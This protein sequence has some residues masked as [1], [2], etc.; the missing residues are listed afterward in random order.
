MKEIIYYRTYS[1]GGEEG[2]TI[3]KRNFDTIELAK[4]DALLDTWNDD[5]SLYEV[6]LTFN[7]RVT[8]NERNL[9]D[10]IRSGRDIVVSKNQEKDMIPRNINPKR[11]EFYMNQKFDKSK[12][13]FYRTYSWGGEEGRTLEKR[14]FETIDLAIDDARKDTWNTGFTIAEVRLMF[15]G[16]I[17]ES[18][19]G[20]EGN[21]KSGRDIE[22]EQQDMQSVNENKKR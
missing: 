13:V 22:L 20:F 6:K 9:E 15:N 10:K 16:R 21:I 19:M 2:R 12:I 11:F 1:Y 7:G 17:E 4:Q 5:F 8:E 14:D 3:E 18:I